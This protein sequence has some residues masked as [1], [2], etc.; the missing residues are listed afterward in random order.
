MR[1]WLGKLAWSVLALLVLAGL[2]VGGLLGT[3]AGSRWVLQQVPGL[4]VEGFT[5]Q[6]GGLWQA[7]RLSW[8]QGE[9]RLVAQDVRLAW[10]PVCLLRR[11]LCLDEL[12]V[13]ALDLQ[14]PP[15]PAA[16]A[17]PTPT[18]PD[19]RLPLNVHVAR[20]AL[21][22]VRLNDSEL[23]REVSL[24]ARWQAEEG[25]RLAALQ[26]RR[27]GL[28][29][30]LAGYLQPVGDWPLEAAGEVLIESPGREPLSVQY[31]LHGP[32]QG[33][34]TVE[35]TSRGWLAGR[36]A[37][38]LSPLESALPVR[39]SFASEA[40]KADAA[41]PDTLTLKAVTLAAEGNRVD[42]YRLRG[43]GR[44]P[45]VGG[46][47]PLL[48]DALLGRDGLRLDELALQA[49]EQHWLRLAGR[50]DW[51]ATPQAE[52]RLRWQAFPWERLYPLDAPVPVTLR[53]LQAELHYEAG[54]Y[55]GNFDSAWT[56]PAGDFDLA[57]PFSGDLQTLHLPQLV[58]SAGPGRASGTLSLGF[59]DGIDWKTQLDLNALNPAYWVAEL[60]GSLAGSLS[61]QGRLAGTARQADAT[62]RLEG[63][64]RGQPALL[65]MQA[66]GMGETWTLAG[67]EAR[68]GSN[69]ITGAGHW[70]Q[71][72]EGRLTLELARL[73]QLWP[74]LQGEIKG[75]L[76]LAGT[77]QLPEGQ[78]ALRGQGV[79]W[80]AQQVRQ[81][82]ML[83]RLDRHQQG[84]L[85]LQ[86]TG[87]RA[88]D[89]TVGELTVEGQGTRE[90]QQASL[91]VR[92][93]LVTLSLALAGGQRGADWLGELSHA[94]LAGYGQQWRLRAPASLE[95]RSDGRLTVGAHCW[96]ADP[97]SMC[98]PAQR[99]TP[100]PQLRYR[101][102]DFPL[103]RLA[104]LLPADLQWEGILNADVDVD[105]PAAGAQGQLRL[106][107]SDGLLRLRDNGQW[108][109][110]P[111]QALT[112]E[113]QLQPERVDGRLRFAGHALGELDV[114]ASIDP[115][116]SEK[117]LR[118]RFRLVG[119]DLSVLR[120]FVPKVE[121]LNGAL[122]G[123]GQ[124]AGSLAQPRIS[125]T[126]DLS[127][128]EVAGGE[129]PVTLEAL[130]A[131]AFIEGEQLRIEGGWR[132]GPYGQ[133]TLAGTLDWRDA[134]VL[135]VRI[136]GQRLPVVVEPYAEVEVSPDL[137]IG[138]AGERLA[139][140]GKVAVP[141]GD[142]VIRELPPATV[143]VSDDA[144]V[145]G[146]TSAEPAR[147]PVQVA[148]DVDVEVG[149]ERLRFAGFGLT[150]DVAGRVHIGDN[151]DTRGELELREGRYQ[152]YGQR[153]SIRRAR[154][155][156]TGPIGQP[157]LDIEAVR[158][159]EP[160]A[161]VAG[162]RI[163]GSTEQPRVEVFSEPAM[164]QEQ[165][166]SYLVLGRP[167]G[168]DQGESSLLARAALGLGLAGGTSI[169][170]GVAE[171]LGIR[172]FQLDTEGSGD[173]TSV[174]ASGQ[175]TERL[176]LRY[177]MGVFEK[178]N[179]IALRYRLTRKLFLEAAS[180]LAS[181]LDLF[182]RRDF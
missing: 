55:L 68:L 111:Y 136:A 141:R 112:L 95:R 182:Y 54:R 9:R 122:N 154:L 118:G 66:S 59:A 19:I 46:D 45:A 114:Q 53:T 2:A 29:L 153:L 139:I 127:E 173:T 27:E 133:A 38:Q 167:L 44:L 147:M 73:G 142:I 87:V 148:M 70:R 155:L 37:G 132:S 15:A 28:T 150:A 58:V 93:P 78:L 152:A 33:A 22:P 99:L 135:D 1:R 85:R 71:T 6:L 12:S 77:P 16:A 149:Q 176:S 100:D 75:D 119:F 131:R 97:A 177:G 124:L 3:T 175:L 115:R 56:G 76:T 180:G 18:L 80:H 82:E 62:L 144:V 84:Q 107:A 123:S 103:S 48:L 51:Q 35:A 36:L 83:G 129:L 106:D 5:G 4:A 17:D 94:M 108:L 13:A 8:V 72:L 157:F 128:G 98:A 146:E 169:T 171:R 96:V 11:T 32:L 92:G 61:S 42:G 161:V 166:L 31:G 86:A 145:I 137:R 91:N 74:G 25:L 164:S 20:L 69:R 101:L 109:A 159:I 160:D 49:D 41:L 172:D 181:S 10:R 138:L 26:L 43:Q 57:S 30:T 151:L 52:V 125:G 23:L 156:F 40:F 117:P 81:L 65:S 102:R 104:G 47:I 130:Q 24:Q 67:L 165:A 178:G 168:A 163:S 64:L 162:L 79:A 89:Q 50:L 158:Q 174:V 88:G 113:S 134:P 110:F 39:L 120:P 7:Q 140:R 90:R 143:K 105:L 121:R 179:T 63:R 170:G 14:W 21:G 116:G 60:P 126:L 34:L